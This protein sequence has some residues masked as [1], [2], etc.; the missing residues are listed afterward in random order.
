MEF[1][2]LMLN[3]RLSRRDS[4]FSDSRSS[5]DSKKC[6]SNRLTVSLD[7]NIQNKRFCLFRTSRDSKSF[8]DS[9]NFNGNMISSVSKICNVNK[10]FNDIKIYNVSRNCSD[11]KHSENSW[12]DIS[13]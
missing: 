13:R 12:N 5:K 9:K 2:C 1:L 10:S 11:S 7:P 4:T 6:K 8:S 3:G